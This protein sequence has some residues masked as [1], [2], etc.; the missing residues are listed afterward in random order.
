MPRIRPSRLFFALAVM[1]GIMIGLGSFTFVYAQGL[2]YMSND[3]RACMNCHIMTDQYNSWAKS[4]HHHVAVCN[5]CHTPHDL[6]GKYT[7]KAINGWNHSRAFTMQDFHEP[8]QITRRNKEI[9]QANCIRCHAD[10]VHAALT[11]RAR[12]EESGVLCVHCHRGV[13]HGPLKSEV[14]LDVVRLQQSFSANP[15]QEMPK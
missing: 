4:G 12:A 8:I 1:I 10:F 5:D 2:S 13:G 7:T 11:T 14:S 3:P 6:V 9:L 15:M